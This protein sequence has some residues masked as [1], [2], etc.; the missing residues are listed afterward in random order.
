MRKILGTI[1]AL[2]IF[3]V[4]TVNAQTKEDSLAIEKSCRDYV[5]GWANGDIDRVS[6]AVS[7]ELIK[8]TVAMDESG[9]CYTINMSSSQLKFVTKRNG[10][11]GVRVNDLEPEKEFELTVEIYDI[12]G[13]CALAK[14]SNTKYGFFDYCQLAKFNGKW[15]IFNVLYGWTPRENN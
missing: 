11:Q 5:E 15:K 7:D 6:T 3:S 14:A 1:L 2:T 9:L 12:T 13:N 4:W 10:E 8:R